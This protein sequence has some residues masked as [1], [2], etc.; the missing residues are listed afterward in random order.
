MNMLWKMTEQ[1]YAANPVIA[2]AL[3][4]CSSCMPI[5]SRIAAP[6]R[7]A[8]WAVRSRSVCLH[9]RGGHRGALWPAAWRRQRRSVADAGRNRLQGQGA[10]PTSPRSRTGKRLLMGFGHRVYKN[11]DPRARILKWAPSAV[12]EITGRNPKLDIALELERIA[13]EDELLHRSASCIPTWTFTPGSSIRRWA[14]ARRCSRYC[15][16]FR[17]PSAGWR[18]G[19]K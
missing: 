19:R 14:S 16:R 6:A 12:F 10:R 17:A 13:L 7:C 18:S 11:Y 1:K 3:D 15:S 2:R 9:R 5:T 4:I 8:A